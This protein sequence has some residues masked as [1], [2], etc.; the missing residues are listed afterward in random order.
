MQ[1]VALGIRTDNPLHVHTAFLTL[2]SLLPPR[3]CRLFLRIPHIDNTAWHLHLAA[4]AISAPPSFC[5]GGGGILSLCHLSPPVSS[6]QRAA[7]RRPSASPLFHAEE[8]ENK[9]LG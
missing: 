3:G 7:G 8:N 5:L 2:A 9:L 1:K 4:V 6:D